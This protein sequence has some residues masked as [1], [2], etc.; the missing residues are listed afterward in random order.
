MLYEVSNSF[1]K[2]DETQG[3]IQNASSGNDIEVSDEATTNS[4]IILKPGES[5]S[6]SGTDIYVRTIGN[7]NSAV[8]VVPFVQGFTAGSTSGSSVAEDLASDYTSILISSTTPEGKN[9]QELVSYINPNRTK[10]ELAEF[11]QMITASTVNT[12]KS[13]HRIDKILCDEESIEVDENLL[14]YLPFTDSATQDLCGN[15][16]SASGSPVI[17]DQ[18]LFL[19]GSSYIKT[20]DVNLTQIFNSDFTLCFYMKYISGQG[21]FSSGLASAVTNTGPVW[22]TWYSNARFNARMDGAWKEWDIVP[23]S[24]YQNS[25]HHFAITRKDNTLYFF[26]DG[27]LKKTY[28]AGTFTCD[29]DVILS[30]GKLGNSPSVLFM[31][32]F[33]VY[34]TCLWTEDFTPE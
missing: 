16:W 21:F 20:N 33:K 5:L 28:T 3:I 23:S 1:V 8:R 12:Y 10:A 11:G 19:D 30:I 17:I 2:I 29:G 22:Q 14:V 13:T 32:H 7:K 9:H 24:Q 6:F 27:V 4:G 31:R 25:E 15:T 26:F 34:S 18:Q